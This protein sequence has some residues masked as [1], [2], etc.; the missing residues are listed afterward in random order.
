M[1]LNSDKEEYCSK[2]IENKQH[3]CW[4]CQSL[5]KKNIQ[6]VVMDKPGATYDKH[7]N[8]NWTEVVKEET[9]RNDRN[10]YTYFKYKVWDY[11][12]VM[13]FGHF[14][15]ANCAMVYGNKAVLLKRKAINSSRNTVANLDKEK[16]KLASKF[17][18]K[19]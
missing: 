17:N 1:Q 10:G 7:P 14:C 18:S 3:R 11:N 6:E 9:Y 12:Y 5:A 8:H 2:K 13:P 4:E 15:T 19:K 16:N